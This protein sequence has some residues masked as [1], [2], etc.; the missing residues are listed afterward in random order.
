MTHMYSIAITYA[1]AILLLLFC[2][3]YNTFN[4]KEKYRNNITKLLIFLESHSLS[5]QIGQN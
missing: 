1:V 3:E 4:T 5:F 2:F